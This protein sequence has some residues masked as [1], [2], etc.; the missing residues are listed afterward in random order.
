MKERIFFIKLLLDYLMNSHSKKKK[1]LCN[2][3]TSWF[4]AFEFSQSYN[5]EYFKLCFVSRLSGHLNYCRVADCETPKYATLTLTLFWA[6]GNWEELYTKSSLPSPICP[7]A[8]HKFTKMPIPSPVSAR[9]DKS[10]SLKTTLDS[11]TKGIY[12]PSFTN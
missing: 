9:K 7:R 4:P 3:C 8:G 1:N 12:I 11:S 10:Q 5:L 2:T 6:Q